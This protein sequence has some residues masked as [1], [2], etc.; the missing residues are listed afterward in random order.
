MISPAVATPVP[1][2]VLQTAKP[3]M[4]TGPV[5][6][7]PKLRTS[8]L[9]ICRIDADNVAGAFHPTDV[10]TMDALAYVPYV[11]STA[12]VPSSNVGL[13]VRRATKH[14]AGTWVVVGNVPRNIL[15]HASDWARDLPAILLHLPEVALMR[16]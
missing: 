10:D 6:A 1:P 2:D 9:V 14:V 5:L 16:R 12:E 11:V 13:V 7:V 4:V 15:R 3:V 8:L